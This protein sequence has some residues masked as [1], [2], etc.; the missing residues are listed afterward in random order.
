MELELFPATHREALKKVHE[1][2]KEIKDSG[3]IID[4]FN[5]A[6]HYGIETAFIPIIEPPALSIPNDYGKYTMYIS[7][8]VDKYS[9][10]ILVYHEL[11]HV[12]CENIPR[13]HLFDHT[14]DHE[15]EFLANYFVAGFLPIFSRTKLTGSTQ[16]E[17]INTYVSSL[18]IPVTESRDIMP[19]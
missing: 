3:I 4:P 16:I 10:K 9:Q 5:I 12:L 2:V 13:I 14:I 6:K 19:L 15:S 18:I 17:D 8:L 11:G 7:S 1:K